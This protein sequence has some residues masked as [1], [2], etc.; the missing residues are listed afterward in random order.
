MNKKYKIYFILIIIFFFLAT[1]LI[2]Q[3]KVIDER[4]NGYILLPGNNIIYKHKDKL[5]IY[6]GEI[7]KPIKIKVVTY[8]NTIITSFTYVNKKITFYN[9]KKETE[10]NEEMIYGYSKNLKLEKIDYSKES[11]NQSDLEKVNQILLE[12]GIIGYEYLNTSEKVSFDFNNDGANETIYFVSNLFDET[13][14]DKVFSLV[15]MINN[16]EINYLIKQVDNKINSYNLCVP[17]LNSIY[18][19]N[20]NKT[21]ITCD[22]FDDI[23]SDIYLYDDQF[24]LI[25]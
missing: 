4:E 7:T 24:N 14:Y 19:I 2:Y 17:S 21:I 1:F 5:E 11:L 9:N 10:L 12:N 25:K 16:N 3:F 22:Y 6:K 20:G 13:I 8:S 23:G 15:F 18:N